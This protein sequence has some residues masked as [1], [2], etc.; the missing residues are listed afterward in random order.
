MRRFDISTAAHS[1]IFLN[2]CRV[3]LRESTHEIAVRHNVVEYGLIKLLEDARNARRAD[4]GERPVARLWRVIPTGKPEAV[5]AQR[6][7]IARKALA[8]I[9][10]TTELHVIRHPVKG[11]S[12]FS[13]RSVRCSLGNR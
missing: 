12:I 5:L 4:F 9:A 1:I 13:T 8:S 6:V 3:R 2:A 11:A 7:T 10:N